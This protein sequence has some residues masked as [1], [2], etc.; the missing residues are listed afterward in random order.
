VGPELAAEMPV[1]LET[2][3]HVVRVP[4]SLDGLV[5]WCERLVADA[6]LRAE[7]QRHA[8]DYFDRYLALPQLGAYYVDRMWQ[9]LR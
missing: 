6:G 4:R 2:G 3:V 7:I 9:T 5:D 1:P 8:V